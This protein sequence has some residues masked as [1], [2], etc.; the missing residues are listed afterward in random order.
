MTGI[1]SKTIFRPL[2]WMYVVDQMGE[3]GLFTV[4]HLLPVLVAVSA[5]MAVEGIIHWRQ[6]YSA[7]L[8]YGPHPESS[9]NF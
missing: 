5:M 8:F 9:G 3:L 1:K 6:P 4:L 7:V 2:P